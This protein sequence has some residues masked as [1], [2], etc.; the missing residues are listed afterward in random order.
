MICKYLHITEITSDNIVLNVSAVTEK[1][2]K[3][4][5]PLNSDRTE[6]NPAQNKEYEN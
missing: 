1:K 3:T 2:I 4:V 6:P 5:E